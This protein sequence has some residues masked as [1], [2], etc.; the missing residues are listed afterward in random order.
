MVK[1]NLTVSRH[2]WRKRLAAVF[3][4]VSFLGLIGLAIPVLSSY[5]EEP[6][7]LQV[8]ETETVL[9]VTERL[10][11]RVPKLAEWLKDFRYSVV[12]N[13]FE[14]LVRHQ[15]RADELV[16]QSGRTLV[17]SDKFFDADTVNQEQALLGILVNIHSQIDPESD[18]AYGE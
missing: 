4:S 2:D 10:E 9:A 18:I 14:I 7:P 5:W 15:W 11:D 17:F 8:E 12:Q 16:L 13:D 3:L 6:R 1:V